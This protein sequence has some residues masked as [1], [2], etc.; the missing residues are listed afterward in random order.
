MVKLGLLDY[1]QVDEGS[2]AREALTNAVELAQ[3]AESLNYQRFWL[4]EHH[5]VPAFASS[6]PELMMMRIADATTNIRLGSGGVMLPHYSPFKVAENFRVLEGYH[7]GRIDLGIGNTVGTPIVNNVLNETKEK[8]L[9]YRKS[10]ADIKQYIL[11]DVDE[12]HRFFGVTANPV[13]PSQPDMW[14]LSTSIARAKMAAEMGIGFTYGHFLTGMDRSS[15]GVEAIQMYREH[16][17]PSPFMQKPCVILA[18]MIVVADT[19]AEAN[20]YRDALDVWL[21]GK[22]NFS[23]YDQ[24]PSV[25][26]AQA[27]AFTEAERAIVQANRKKMIIGDKKAVQ[28]QLYALIDMFHV[29]EVLAVLLLP[30]FAARKRAVQLISEMF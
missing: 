27:Y 15:I 12:T 16:F 24:F 29:D 2:D 19:E 6:S 17:T 5:N 8:K 30:T 11:D 21:L 26:T 7:P 10:I 20:A 4:A 23:F 3:L 28:E 14:V 13:I 22:D 25:A 1:A 18:P 9:S